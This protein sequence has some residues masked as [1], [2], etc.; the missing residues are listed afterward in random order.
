MCSVFKGGRNE[1]AERTTNGQ[2]VE[3]HSCYGAFIVSFSQTPEHLS[4]Q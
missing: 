4:P 2:K 1:M 3:E